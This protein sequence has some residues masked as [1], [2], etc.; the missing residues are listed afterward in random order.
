[1]KKFT[2]ISVIA[3]SGVLILGACGGKNTNTTPETTNPPAT[4]GQGNTTTQENTNTVNEATHDYGF[5]KF[6]LEIDV[7]GK[8]AIDV[9]YKTSDIADSDYENKLTNINVTGDAAMDELHKLFMELNITANKAQQEIIDQI[10]KYFSLDSYS[11]FDLEVD[12]NDGT[13]LNIEDVK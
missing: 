12:F 5:Q 6:D 13:K 10:M 9:D 1:M 8:D 4:N 7:D 3:L 2:V 11:K